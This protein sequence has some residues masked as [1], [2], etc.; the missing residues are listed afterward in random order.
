MQLRTK[1]I[2]E[3]E[4]ELELIDRTIGALENLRRLRLE[5]I[6]APISLPRRGKASG[7]AEPR[8]RKAQAL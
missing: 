1:S 3:L 7:S 2:E 8:P 6:P 4:L 5:T